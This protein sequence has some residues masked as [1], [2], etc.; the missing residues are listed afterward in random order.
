M[1][2]P[3]PVRR[4]LVGFAL[5]VLLVLAVMLLVRPTIFT[6][7]PP[8]D[9]SVVAVGTLNEVSAAPRRVEVVLSDS[10][11]WDGEQ[12]ADDGRTQ[13]GVIVGPTTTGFAAVN[14]ASPVADDCPVEITA[15]RLTDCDGRS[16]TFAGLPIDSADPPLQ[17]FP[18]TVDGGSVFVDFTRTID[19]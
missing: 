14:A 19:S 11:G 12:D 5:I 16:W 8:R 3:I 13:L 2:E 10:Y 7:A 15:D 9:D 1:D 18:I 17:R 6:L 4:V